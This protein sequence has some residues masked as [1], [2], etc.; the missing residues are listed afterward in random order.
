MILDHFYNMS[1]GN[2]IYVLFI[3]QLQ[4]V[5]GEDIRRKELILLKPMKKWA[6]KKLSEFFTPSQAIVISNEQGGGEV[7]ADDIDWTPIVLT[8]GSSSKSSQAT[9]QNNNS[10]NGSPD[11]KTS[12]NSSRSSAEKKRNPKHQ[13]RLPI[14]EKEDVDDREYDEDDDDGVRSNS[15]VI[16]AYLEDRVNTANDDLLG[17]DSLRNYCEE[18]SEGSEIDSLSSACHELIS[19]GEEDDEEGYTLERLQEVGPPLSSLAPLLKHVLKSTAEISTRASPS[20]SDNMLTSYT[21]QP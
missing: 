16:R 17:V 20:N 10:S 13:F 5:T 18:G 15:P 2:I 6:A 19:D 21:F 11:S 9:S 7:D 3:V 4:S 8:S 12:Q 14:P 1:T